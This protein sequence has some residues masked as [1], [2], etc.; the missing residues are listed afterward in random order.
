M[1]VPV[2][3]LKPV[4]HRLDMKTNGQTT[5]LDDAYNSNPVGSRAALDV[6]ALFDDG[7]RILVTPGMVELG[8]K[9]AAFNRDFG[10]DMASAAEVCVLI[11]KKHTQP[12]QEGLIE[13]G[14]PPEDMHVFPSL[15]DA[16]AWLKGFMRPGDFI[17]YENDLPDHYSET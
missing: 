3:R 13:A 16:T 12:I 10:R 7:L 6:L 2:R 5:I 11:G 8:D 1:R 14:Y 17:L 9:E 15:N 4:E